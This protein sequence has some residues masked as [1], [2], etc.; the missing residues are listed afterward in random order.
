LVA[1]TL[2]K[3]AGKVFVVHQTGKEW[4]ALTDTP[5]YVSRPFFNTEMPHLYAGADLILGRAGAGTLWEAAATGVPLVLLPLGA[6]SRGD[7]VRNAEL[8][9]T[10][11]A[12]RVLGPDAD[13]DALLAEVSAF[14][15]HPVALAAARTALAGFD[16][17]GAAD[18][19]AAAVLARHPEVTGV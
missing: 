2:P 11:G 8:F 7:Q 10:R 9:A 17:A 3:L 12:A 13:P 1:E 4:T 19:I 5:W 18:R 15:D 14:L 6:G 16:A